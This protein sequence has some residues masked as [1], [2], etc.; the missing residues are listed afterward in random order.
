[1][2]EKYLNEMK[3]RL[4]PEEQYS[5]IIAKINVATDSLKDVERNISYKYKVKGNSSI[6]T[7]DIGPD[8]VNRRK[9]LLAQFAKEITVF[10]K[11][12]PK[13]IRS[14]CKVKDNSFQGNST[15]RGESGG[16]TVERGGSSGERRRSSGERQG[17]SEQRRGSSGERKESYEENKGNSG[18]RGVSSGG[19]GVSSGG[20]GVNSG[21]GGRNTK[22]RGG[23]SGGRRRNNKGREGSS[24]GRGGSSGVSTNG[25]TE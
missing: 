20:K 15:R 12:F 1:M 17:R 10:L 24:R 22:G 14:M 3:V 5:N 7:C 23:S 25:V 4:T 19:K 6:I 13:N 9:D 11:L 21:G 8:F 18:G 2:F 16:S